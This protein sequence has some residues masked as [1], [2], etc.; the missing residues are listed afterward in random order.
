VNLAILLGVSNYDNDKISNLTACTYDV[1]LVHF[2]LKSTK[3]YEDILLLDK[4]TT[5]ENVKKQL[6]EFIRKHTAEESKEIDEV[7]FYYT[8]HGELYKDEFY[9]ILS[10]FD[11]DQ[12]NSTSLKNGELD[13]LLRN[14][15]PKLTVKFV[16]ACQS[17]ISYV[18]DPG[19]MRIE[20]VVDNG[21]HTFQNCYFMFSSHS[22]QFSIA[23][24]KISLFTNSFLR[25]I[26]R[27]NNGDIRYADIID[28]IKDD[29][30]QPHSQQT[31]YFIIQ[32]DYTKFFVI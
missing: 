2:L 10:N 16:D 30:S 31:P 32:A 15:N 22:D 3:K 21:K 1:N 28:R 14:L 11:F 17:G 27:F 20:K 18:K 26:S 4:N 24:D 25:A 29:F 7:F 5:S 6:T 8:G 9:Y 12:R 23:T 19:E 13:N